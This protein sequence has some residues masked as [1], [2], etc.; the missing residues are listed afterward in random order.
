MERATL[1]PQTPSLDADSVLPMIQGLARLHDHVA[2]FD[3]EGRVVW[4]SDALASVCGGGRRFKGRPW[5]E[6]LADPGRHGHLVERLSATGRLSNEAL[7]LTGGAAAHL[8]AT[9][10]AA[11]LGPAEGCG[12]SVAIFRVDE[13]AER[14]DRELRLRLDYLAAILDSAPEGVVV[15][16]RSRFITYVNP[17]MAEITGYGVD[18]LVDRPLA[19]FLRAQDD[20]ERI[21]AALEPD[22]GAVR[23]RDVRVRRRDGSPLCASVSASLLRLPDGTPLGAVAYVCDVSERRRAEEDLARKNAELEHYV[24]AVSHDLRSPLVALLG[25]SRLLREDFADA[26]GPQGCHFVRRIEEAGRTME[27]LIQDL[28]E[29]SRIGR[30]KLHKEWVEP[31]EVLLQLQ[32]EIKPRLEATG[33]TLRIPEAPP[34]LLCDRTRLYQILSNL[35]GNALDHMGPC[36]RPTV[37]VEIVAEPESH[38]VR[39]RDNGRGIAPEDQERIF[40]LF[41][42]LSERRGDD[43]GTGIGLAIVKKI[44]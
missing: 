19:L 23:N 40:E 27:A 6:L 14:L 15:V 34:L 21:A 2:L 9:V 39:V 31:R 29:L 1:S 33:V 10:S 17:A 32:A 41:Q 42:S 35:I 25:F 3:G 43:G 8:P 28:L 38:V 11:R 7:R 16:D 24:H 26:L 12:A 18:E 20:V 5:S 13:E 22:G 4:L 30:S 44:A 37:T 36:D